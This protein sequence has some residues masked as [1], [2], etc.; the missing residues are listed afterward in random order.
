MSA[1]PAAVEAF[2][3]KQVSC[4][5]SGDRE[6]FFQA[7]ADIAPG[8]L[9]IEYVGAHSGDGIPILEGM[10]EQSRPSIEIEEVALIVIGDEAVAHNRNKVKGS[11]MVIETI[12]QYRFGDDGSVSVRYFIKKP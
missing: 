9:H 4:W 2:M 8:G 6:G 1:S 3:H 11:D 12:E 7:Y 5:N 10:W